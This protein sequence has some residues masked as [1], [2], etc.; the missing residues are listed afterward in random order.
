MDPMKR[1]KLER[2][3]DELL[4]VK[5]GDVRSLALKAQSELKAKHWSNVEPLVQRAEKAWSQVRPRRVLDLLVHSG[6][7]DTPG[8]ARRLVQAGKVR[9]NDVVLRKPFATAGPDDTVTVDGRR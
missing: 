6:A 1:V 4:G 7:A 5:D 3:I 9:V 2:R 8:Q